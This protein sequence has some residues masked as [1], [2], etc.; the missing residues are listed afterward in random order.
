M[1]R[2][3]SEPTVLPSEQ[4]GKVMGHSWKLPAVAAL[5][6]ITFAF[7]ASAQGVDQNTRQQIEKIIA[8]YHEN[9]N[10]HDAAGIAGLYTNDGVL[11]NT[12]AAVKNGPQEIEQNYQNVFKTLSHHDGATIDQL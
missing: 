2:R 9:W 7:S 1:G 10:N 3:R 4:G 8:T 12:A 5:G 6:L 11:V